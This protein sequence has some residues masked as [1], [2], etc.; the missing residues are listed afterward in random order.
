MEREN[1]SKEKQNKS[2]SL[3]PEK[4]RKVW[5]SKFFMH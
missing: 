3:D 1:K 4:D 5:N 2:K